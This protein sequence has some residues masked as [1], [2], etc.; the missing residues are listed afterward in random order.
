MAERRIFV[1]LDFRLDGFVTTKTLFRLD[2]FAIR[3]QR[4][5][6]FLMQK[7]NNKELWLY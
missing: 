1:W 6:V 3:P 2:G 7:R 5:S 4:I